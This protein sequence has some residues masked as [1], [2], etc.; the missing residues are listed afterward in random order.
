MPKCS[1]RRETDK[2]ICKRNE[3]Y[4]RVNTRV[5][6][7]PRWFGI[8]IIRLPLPAN[9]CSAKARARDAVYVCGVNDIFRL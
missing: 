8:V 5:Y 1:D 4:L 7:Q 3:L 2:Y 6:A 9:A